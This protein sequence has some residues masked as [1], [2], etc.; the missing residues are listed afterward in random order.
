MLFAVDR[1]VDRNFLFRIMGKKKYIQR[2]SY[3]FQII[4][5]RHSVM[6][7]EHN[8]ESFHPSTANWHFQGR[9]PHLG[10]LLFSV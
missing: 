10:N 7:S 8:S 1:I 2:L 6:P 4:E 3:V 5:L 9:N